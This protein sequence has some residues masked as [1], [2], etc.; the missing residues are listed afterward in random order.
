MANISNKPELNVTIGAEYKVR[1]TTVRVGRPV[2]TVNSPRLK[3]DNTEYTDTI[4][5]STGVFLAGTGPDEIQNNPPSVR[6]VENIMPVGTGTHPIDVS[7]TGTVCDDSIYP[8]GYLPSYGY[9]FFENLEAESGNLIHW[10][11]EARGVSSVV[12]GIEYPDT[13]LVGLLQPGDKSAFRLSPSGVKI[14]F[15]SASGISAL[16]D[17]TISNRKAR[18]KYTLFPK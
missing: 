18:L 11:I 7:G 16:A 5:Q 6:V 12:D 10:G 13:A 8:S 14:R 3:K 2:E 15:I 9:T 4:I 1:N 17:G